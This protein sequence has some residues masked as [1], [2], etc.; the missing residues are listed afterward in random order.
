VARGHHDQGALAGQLP[1]DL[2]PEPAVGAGHHGD[3]ARLVGD[4]GG[5]PG[6]LPVPAPPRRLIVCGSSEPWKYRSSTWRNTPCC[7]S[8]LANRVMEDRSLMASTE[9]RMSRASF[10]PMSSRSWGHSA[11]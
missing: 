10:P 3:P 4:V 6:H 1:G 7:G 8:A 5:G 9:P 2:E 11:G